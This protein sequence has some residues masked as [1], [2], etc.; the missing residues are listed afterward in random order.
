MYVTLCDSSVV[1]KTVMKNEH[2]V[3]WFIREFE[4]DYG[5][6]SLNVTVVNTTIALKKRES[7]K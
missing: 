3:G 4:W 1:K 5:E 7:H 6:C 2:T